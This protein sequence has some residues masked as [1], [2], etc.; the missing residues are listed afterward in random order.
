[1]YGFPATYQPVQNVQQYNQPNMPQY[2]AYN[3]NQIPQ[4]QTAQQV[5][6]TPA[7][8]FGGL[9]RVQSIEDVYRWEIHQ[10]E[11]II[12]ITNDGSFM[13]TKELGFSPMDRPIVKKFRA[14]DEQQEAASTSNVP[15]PM[16]DMSGYA[17]KSEIED[18]KLEI[19]V[20]KE[21]LANMRGATNEK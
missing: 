6:Q 8:Q 21:Q 12:F 4:P 5:P 9:F 13:L 14:F 1:M 11:I 16:P 7:F 19:D 10:G 20:L 15:V 18:L 17:H 3:N 2:P